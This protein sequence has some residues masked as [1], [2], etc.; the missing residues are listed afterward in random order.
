M[1]RA[2]AALLVTVAA[3]PAPGAVRSGVDAAGRLVWCEGRA[4]PRLHEEA[5][6][7]SVTRLR[8]ERA[9]REEA[10]RGCLAAIRGLRVGEGSVGDRLD[11]APRQARDVE[12]TVRSSRPVD[13]PRLLA[14]GGVALRL[15]I[16]VD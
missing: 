14:D 13:A 3:A 12:A 4:A 2:F 1:L 16:P 15:S 11:R 10:V 8:T 9:A 5:G 6:N 7:V